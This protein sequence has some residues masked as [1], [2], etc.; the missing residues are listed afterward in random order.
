MD[1]SAARFRHLIDGLVLAV[2][3]LG[4]LYVAARGALAPTDQSTGVAVVFAPWTPA[5]IAM[6]RSVEA[7]SRFIRFGAL[8]FIAVVMPDHPDFSKSIDRA[9]AW[10]VVD[11]KAVGGCLADA[12]IA[13]R[14][15]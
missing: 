7:G 8:S 3:S 12:S 5:D 10:F 14:K 13:A 15:S 6:I 4:A 2:L 11:P 1:A 9:G